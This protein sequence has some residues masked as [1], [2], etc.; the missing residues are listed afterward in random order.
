ME[1]CVCRGRLAVVGLFATPSTAVYD[2]TN[3]CDADDL[4]VS[5]LRMGISVGWGDRYGSALPDQ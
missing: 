3:V 2:R 4:N 5:S 1:E